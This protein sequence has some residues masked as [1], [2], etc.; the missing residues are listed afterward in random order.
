MLAGMLVVE[1]VALG[2]VL[3]VQLPL[4]TAAS[5]TIQRISPI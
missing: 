1:G 5:R 4:K 2:M 3:P